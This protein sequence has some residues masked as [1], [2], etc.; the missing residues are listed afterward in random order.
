M[1]KPQAKNDNRVRIIG[2]RWRGRK[3]AFVDGEGLRP[4]GDRIRETLFNWLMPVLPD[5]HCLDVFAGSG[6][7]G[8]EAL[9][10]GA[11]HC[12]LLE[13]NAHAVR[14]LRA[15]QQLL[16]ADAAQIV[17]ADSES[18]LATTSAVFD[19]VFIDPPFADTTLSPA[20]LV[21]L[22]EQRKLL[23]ED[24]WIYVEQ[25]AT[26]TLIPPQGFAIFRQQRAGQVCFGL[27]RRSEKIA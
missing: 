24:P 23:A 26:A 2:G 11:A 3:I 8:F 13:R 18:W 10:R 25:P 17:L 6:A 4:T 27:W 15:A 12:T 20:A 19:M 7:L 16:A 14:G 22:M 9:S 21:A 5:A 1:R